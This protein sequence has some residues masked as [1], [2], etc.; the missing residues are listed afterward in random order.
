MQRL[1][2]PHSHT[3]LCRYGTGTLVHSPHL[4]AY[5]P[6]TIMGWWKLA[7]PLFRPEGTGL[8][9]DRSSSVRTFLMDSMSLNSADVIGRGIPF[10]CH[11]VITRYG[12]E[13]ANTMTSYALQILYC[14]C[15]CV[16]CVCGCVG[17]WVC[18]PVGSRDKM[19]STC[20]HSLVVQGDVYLGCRGDCSHDFI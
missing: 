3:L 17:V 15:V 18:L 13:L 11:L 4:L 8:N 12:H 20:F 1:M 19:K 14:V 16:L 6:C 5:D 7:S 10:L 2:Q 9:C